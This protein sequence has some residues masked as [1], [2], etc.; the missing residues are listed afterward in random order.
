V[1]EHEIGP[2]LSRSLAFHEVFGPAP[3][4]RGSQFGMD[5]RSYASVHGKAQG[6]KK[7]FCL[8]RIQA[9]TK[10]E[11]QKRTDNEAGPEIRIES[12]IPRRCGIQH[13]VQLRFIHNAGIAGECQRR[14]G[15]VGPPGI[16]GL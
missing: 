2:E 1:P 3:R 8:D 5:I 6:L 11:L 15:G 13:V 7:R 12:V 4:L 14:R 10:L 16:L 9:D